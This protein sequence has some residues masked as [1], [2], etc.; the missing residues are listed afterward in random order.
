MSS[1]SSSS[2][3]H[4]LLLSVKSKN[5]KKCFSDAET[6]RFEI[7]DFLQYG[8]NES[9]DT[10]P[11]KAHGYSWRLTMSIGR[12]NDYD[13]TKEAAVCLWHDDTIQDHSP[14]ATVL[15][16]CLND[17]STSESFICDYSKFTEENF[18]ALVLNIKISA[19][20]HCHH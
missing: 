7:H 19:K 14:S 12:Y 11:L 5:P 8:F 1:T 13:E 18:P 4:R 3:I 17:D 6:L 20:R 15:L 2:S 10:S 9:I 16:R